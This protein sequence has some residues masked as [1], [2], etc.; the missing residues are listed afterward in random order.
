MDRVR[1]GEDRWCK[2]TDD[3]RWESEKRTKYRRKARWAKREHYA[4][5]YVF[6]CGSGDQ[7]PLPIFRQ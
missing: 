6:K 7:L 1:L 4:G 3:G 2:K 5:D